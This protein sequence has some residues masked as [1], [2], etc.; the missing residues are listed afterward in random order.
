M[1]QQYQN[2]GQSNAN[3]KDTHWDVWVEYCQ[4]CYIDPLDSIPYLQVFARRYHDGRVAPRGKPVKSKIVSDGLCSVGQRFA[5]LSAN[6]PRLNRFG[7]LEFCLARQKH[8]YLKNRCQFVSSLPLWLSDF[9]RQRLWQN[10]LQIWSVSPS[11][12]VF[13]PVN[14]QGQRQMTRHSVSMMWCCTLTNADSPM[15]SL[16]TMIF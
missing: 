10:R 16:Q 6:N 2:N 7:K 5:N 13:V 9:V 12:F 15:N 4:K 3:K 11:S 8:C 14:I 1:P